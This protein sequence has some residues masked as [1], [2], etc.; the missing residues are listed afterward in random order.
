MVRSRRLRTAGLSLPKLLIIFI[1]HV[2]NALYQMIKIK[3]KPLKGIDIESIGEVSLGESRQN[4][5]RLL[6]K[7]SK[8]YS[9]PSAYYDQYEMRIDFDKLE[10]V[11]YIEFLYGPFPEKA[12]LLIYDINPFT[13]GAEKLVEILSKYNNGEVDL[14][15]AEYSYAFLNSSVG[16]WREVTQKDVEESITELKLK[17]EYEFNK[18]SFEDELEN[19]KNFWTIGIGIAD[20]YK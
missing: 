5:E 17:G 16:I 1:I 19:S 20:Y 9:N 15:N 11:E 10:R 12:E 8:P 4:I 13:L 3:I 18:S 14:S 2:I 7:P 6:G